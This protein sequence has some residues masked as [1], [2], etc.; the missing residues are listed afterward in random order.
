MAGPA[1][2]YTVAYFLLRPA[3]GLIHKYGSTG[4][5]VSILAFYYCFSSLR[6]SEQSV[7][8]A[9]SVDDSVHGNLP[10]ISQCDTNVQMS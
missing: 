4:L 2:N 1:A 3:H 9:S 10:V 8:A 7:T 5:L 6:K